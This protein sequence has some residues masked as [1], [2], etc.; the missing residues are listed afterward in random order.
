MQ[1]YLAVEGHGTKGLK[2][3]ADARSAAAAESNLRPQEFEDQPDQEGGEGAEG[4]EGDGDGEGGEAGAEGEESRASSRQSAPGSA[5]SESFDGAGLGL[6]MEMTEHERLWVERGCPRMRQ[7]QWWRM[8]KACQMPSP[9]LRQ[10]QVNQLFM[11][12]QEEHERPPPP[13]NESEMDRIWRQSPHHALQ[14]ISLYDFAELVVRV[15]HGRYSE[16]PSLSARLKF[17]MEREILPRWVAGLDAT[18]LRVSGLENAPTAMEVEALK[19]EKGAVIPEIVKAPLGDRFLLNY[20]RQDVQEY[21]GEPTRSQKL[22]KCFHFI[23]DTERDDPH[24]L[25]TFNRL[26]EVTHLS[27]CISHLSWYLRF[28]SL[29]SRGVR[30]ICCCASSLIRSSTSRRP[31]SKVTP[32]L[33]ST[34]PLAS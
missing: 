21:L 31:P 8:C 13:E 6:V 27:V 19:K 14:S 20:W 7:F 16:M 30:S 5:S 26:L 10:Y 11:R 34:S 12:C 18:A 25:M 29:I 22:W 4:G 23:A 15:A 33:H 17:T 24:A 28:A 2:P 3:T 1:A 32:T 9:D